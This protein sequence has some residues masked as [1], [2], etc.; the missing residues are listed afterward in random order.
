[1]PNIKSAWE[2][3]QE[4]ASKLGSLSSQEREEQRHEKCRLLGEALADK[5]LN[6]RDIRTIKDELDKHEIPDK[7]WVA[8]A[9]IR[10]LGQS[11]DLKYPDALPEISK[12]TLAVHDTATT[13]KALEEIEILFQEYTEAA[14][15]QS[16][17]I[18]EAGGQILHQLRI[19][20]L[21]IGHIN[22]LA[23]EEWQAKLDQT[24]EPFT[25]RLKSLKEEL[26][27]RG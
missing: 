17:E 2:I 20:G 8:Q 9:V 23:Q 12:G 26:L 25:E 13:R 3:A 24:A 15:K 7:D 10:R 27:H 19:S 5:Y 6:Q 18:E 4:K 11:I 14:K 21:A 1:M 22:I 16:Q